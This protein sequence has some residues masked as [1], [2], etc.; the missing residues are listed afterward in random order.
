MRRLLLALA[1]LL[2]TAVIGAGAST[3]SADRVYA[4]SF[5][6]FLYKPAKLPIG[7]H[8]FVEGIRWGRWGGRTATGRGTFDYADATLQFRAPVRV[9]LSQRKRCGGKRAYLGQRLLPVRRSDARRLRAFGRLWT[10]VC[11]NR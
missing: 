7:A 10:G 2:A 9:V 3:A 11:P 8:G 6:R 5:T 1:A 4:A